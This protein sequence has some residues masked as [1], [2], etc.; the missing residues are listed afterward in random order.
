MAQP[1]RY[2]D[3]YLYSTNNAASVEM[4]RFLDE[5]MIDYQNLNYVDA[6]GKQ[7]TLSALSTWFDDKEKNDGSK[8]EFTQFPI[9]VFEQL[10]W[11]SDDKSERLQKRYFAKSKEEIPSDFIQKAIKLS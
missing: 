2:T 7:A 1:I 3:I 5:H 10:F 6:D 4:R 11:E 8:V 9:L